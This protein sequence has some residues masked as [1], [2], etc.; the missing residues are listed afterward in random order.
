M[1]KRRRKNVPRAGFKRRTTWKKGKSFIS[2]IKI[3]EPEKMIKDDPI[4][5][6]HYRLLKPEPIE[7]I[8]SWNLGFH[9][10]NAVK[11]ICRA[12]RKGKAREDIKKAIWYLNRFVDSL[13]SEIIG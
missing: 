9:L 4:N 6:A 12:E 10:G 2:Y 5:P 3:D 1:A 13:P 8:E 7:V 11:Y